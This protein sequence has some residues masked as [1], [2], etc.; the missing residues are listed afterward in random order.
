MKFSELSTDRALDVMC[1]LS[2]NIAG[3]IEDEEVLA[4]LDS[5]MS[6]RKPDEEEKSSVD[7]IKMMGGMVKIAPVLLKTHRSDVYGILSVMNERPVEEI[8]AQKLTE[9]IR[10]VRELL[11]EEEF[12]TF[13]KSSAQQGQAEQSA[14]SASSPASE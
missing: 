4:A 11:Q 12:M 9:T 8:A 1:E 2:P 14:L 6:M 5:V 3:I 13:F 10:Q 7:G